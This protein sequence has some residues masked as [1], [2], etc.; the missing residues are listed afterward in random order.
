M[1]MT[2]MI[3]KVTQTG[4]CPAVI[5]PKQVCQ[6]LGIEVGD[7]VVVHIVGKIDESRTVA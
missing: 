3:L 6:N 7:H 2:Y 1:E 5:I 4:N